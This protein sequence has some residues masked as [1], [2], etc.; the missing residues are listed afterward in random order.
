MMP[1][2]ERV[3]SKSDEKVAATKARYVERFLTD[4]ALAEDWIAEALG[5]LNAIE[6]AQMTAPLLDRALGALP[7]LKARHKIFFVGNWLAA[8]I[9][10]Q[11]SVAALVVVR[12]HA[13]MEHLDADLRLKVLEYAD[14]LARTIA[15]RARFA[16]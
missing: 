2:S 6:H 1:F 5:P 12:R 16:R 10:G 4:T 9:G 13:A 14:G 3:R 15:I 8:F 11:N 7:S